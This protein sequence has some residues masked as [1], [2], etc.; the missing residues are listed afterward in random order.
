MQNGP[1]CALLFY[2]S[3]RDFHGEADFILLHYLVQRKPGL[4]LKHIY[5]RDRSV[6]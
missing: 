6:F 5:V 2:V 1:F 4:Y 3:K